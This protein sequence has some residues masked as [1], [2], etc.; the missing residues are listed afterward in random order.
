MKQATLF[1]CPVCAQVLYEDQRRYFCSQ[2]HN[3][4]VAKQGYVNL[5]LPHHIGSGNPGDSPEMLQKRRRF[6]SQGYYQP[7]SDEV[8]ALVSKVVAANTDTPAIL[9]AGCGEGYYTWR[10]WDKLKDRDP[11]IYG[12]DVSK[13]AVQYA[14]KKSREIRFAVGTNYRLPFLRS[15]MDCILSLFA[16]RDEEEFA[17]VLKPQGALIVAAPGRITC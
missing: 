8:N 3:F 2:G 17:A 12:I 16:P 5:L 11:D 10:L 6:L 7:F 13:K 14:A 15:S 1:Q 4:D 9:D